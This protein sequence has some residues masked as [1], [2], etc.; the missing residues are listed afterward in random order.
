MPKVIFDNLS[1]KQAK[2]FVNWYEGQGEQDS[3][4]W[5][6]EKEVKGIFIDKIKKDEDGNYIVSIK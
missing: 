4:V 2:E 1:K 3:Y 5:L 6:Q